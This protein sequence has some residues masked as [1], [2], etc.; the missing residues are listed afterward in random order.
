MSEEVTQCSQPVPWTRYKCSHDVSPAMRIIDFH[1]CSEWSLY[2]SRAPSP[3]LPPESNDMVVLTSNDPIIK[4]FQT[5]TFEVH[6]PL[7]QSPVPK[8]GSDANIYDRGDGAA[9]AQS[10]HSSVQDDVEQFESPS[11]PSL[12]SA[13]PITHPHTAFNPKNPKVRP[14]AIKSVRSVQVPLDSY[15]TT[16]IVP[17]WVDTSLKKSSRPPKRLR[18]GTLQFVSKKR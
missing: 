6:L 15:R 3:D 10:P 9:I 4:P 5:H 1:D 13:I 17:R 18:Q 7:P 8:I 16:P 14:I 2:I 12:P 11:S